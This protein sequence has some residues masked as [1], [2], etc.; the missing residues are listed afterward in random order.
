M[1]YLEVFLI[2][3]GGTTTAL[4]IAGSLSRSLLTHF[5]AKEM[6]SYKSKLNHENSV[7]LEALKA[8]LQQSAKTEDRLVEYD[9]VMKRYQGPL[10]HAVYDLQSRLFNILVR[11]FIAVYFVDGNDHERK[12]VVNN[13]V[14]V[15]AQYF[16]WTEI[17][18]NEIQF[19]DFRSAAQTRNLSELRDNIYHLWQTDVF[20]D[21]FRI[22]AGEQRAIGEL[23]IEERDKRLTCI[24]YAGFLKKLEDGREPLFTQLQ[25]DV[26]ALTESG[27]ASHPRLTEIQNSL[28]D[29]L[30]YLDPDYLRFPEKRR[31]YVAKT[32]PST[33]P[34]NSSAKS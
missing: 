3:I 8:E 11:G 15:I 1:E 26:V 23:M 25:A 16:A 29:L 2:S 30:K 19:L 28:I 12:Y 10:I 22:W 20:D 27:S 18:R 31:T 17:I 34:P 7:A 13:T 14:F 21:S 33:S 5:F 24:G 9:Q 4:L 32:G 6:E